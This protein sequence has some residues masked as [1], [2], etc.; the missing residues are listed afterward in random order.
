[1]HSP[2]EKGLHADREVGGTR[3]KIGTGQESFAVNAV[4]GAASIAENS[5]PLREARAEG[6]IGICRVKGLAAVREW[7]AE[8]SAT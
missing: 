4:S 3:I 6:R 8:L 5:A 7:G 1:M 2:T